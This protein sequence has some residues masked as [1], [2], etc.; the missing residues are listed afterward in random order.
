MYLVWKTGET[1]G[2]LGQVILVDDPDNFNNIEMNRSCQKI[3]YFLAA[4]YMVKK[5]K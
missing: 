1:H 3:L 4:F 5:G 2:I